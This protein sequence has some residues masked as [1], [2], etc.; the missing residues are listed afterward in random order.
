MARSETPGTSLPPDSG[1][2]DLSIQ[3]P[4][5]QEG[6]DQRDR[7][8]VLSVEGVNTTG[9]QDEENNIQL[10]QVHDAEPVNMQS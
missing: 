7:G 10:L 8:T 3:L 2:E 5:P 4:I 1:S 6:E 9:T